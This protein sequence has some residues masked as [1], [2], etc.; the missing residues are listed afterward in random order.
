[1]ILLYLAPV[2]FASHRPRCSVAADPW[3]QWAAFAALFNPMGNV[4]APGAFPGS[5]A[6]FTPFFDVERF[7]A[8]ARAFQQ[9]GQDSQAAAAFGDFLRDQFGG[10]LDGMWGGSPPGR[11]TPPAH[12]APALG[13]TREQQ[14][15]WQRGA[16]AGRR[17]Q[18]AQRRLQ[19]LWSDTLGEAARAFIARAGAAAAPLTPEAIQEL[20]DAWV[21]CAEEAYA[22]MAHAETYGTA[23]A[24]AVKAASEWRDESA[25]MMESWAKWLDWPTRSEINSLSMRVRALEETQRESTRKNGTTARPAGKKRATAAKKRSARS[26]RKR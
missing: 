3:R 17:L 2:P 23:L 21:D 9:S 25:A 13:P 1:M 6:G 15:R 26:K 10:V 5:A 19:R 24:E 18:E 22:R 16:A 4:S 20:Y 11:S 7:A 12:E 8:A 14:E